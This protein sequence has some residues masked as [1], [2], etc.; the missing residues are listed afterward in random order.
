VKSRIKNRWSVLLFIVLLSTAIIHSQAPGDPPGRNYPGRNTV[1]GIVF[2]PDRLPA[3]RGIAIRLSKGV[4]DFTAWTDQDGKFVIRGVD[5]GTYSLIVEAGD[6]FEPL[7]E[8]FEIALASGD[9]AQTYNFDL[10]LRFKLGTKPKPGV[11]DATMAGVPSKAQQHYQDA[12]AAIAKG[13]YQGGVNELLLAVAQYPEFT[14]AHTELGTQYQRLNQ[15]EKSEEHLRIAL[16]QSPGAYNPL[17]TLGVVLVRLGKHAEAESV[18][19][20]AVKIKDDSAVVRFYLGRA[21][22]SQKR[23][24]DAEPEFRA[25]L[26]LGGKDMIEARRS[27]ANIYLQR[28]DDKMALDEI[29]AY[30]AADTKPADEKKLRDTVQQ[31]KAL[32]KENQKP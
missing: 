20:E 29:E 13:D 12:L 26:N 27:L 30:L 6:E 32:L 14:N 21:L 16:K 22:L 9:P 3:G 1:T 15:F 8:R 19:R 24:D 23:L 18:L 2:K 17:A 31:L 5:N 28:G 10:R 4:N 7:R 11:V 25:A